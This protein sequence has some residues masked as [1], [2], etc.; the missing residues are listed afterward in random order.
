MS[1]NPTNQS[2]SDATS[3]RSSC[4]LCGIHFSWPKKPSCATTSHDTRSGSATELDDLSPSAFPGSEMEFNR[5]VDTTS[6][7]AERDRQ[8]LIE[9]GESLN[10]DPLHAAGPSN[11]TDSQTGASGS[12]AGRW[13][14]PPPQRSRRDQRKSR[15][16]VRH[17]KKTRLDSWMVN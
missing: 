1:S 8:K 11:T 3:P 7:A 15:H 17:G 2:A 9:R 6:S 5:M 12:Q 10:K 14:C 4:G 13:R 16:P